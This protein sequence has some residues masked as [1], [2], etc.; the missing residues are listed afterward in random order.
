M[1][2]LQG[3][4]VSV[5]EDPG[6]FHAPKATAAVTAARAGFVT[7]MECR[8]LGW[9]VQRLG[10]GRAHP[11]D[12]VS[13]HAGIEMLVKV[14]DK[15]EAGQ[16]LVTLFAEEEERL[17]EAAEM[18]RGAIAIGDRRPEPGRLIREVLTKE[19]VGDSLA[20]R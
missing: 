17:A 7:A 18:V 16:A 3:G 14:G 19:S 15:V 5:F 11:G 12:P 2:S 13:A 8:E 9:A 20:E 10:A 1:V 4:D 6:A